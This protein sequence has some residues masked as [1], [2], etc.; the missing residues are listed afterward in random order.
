MNQ[1]DTK[2]CRD[3]PFSS[4]GKINIVKMPAL[5]KTTYRFNAIPM[6]LLVAFSTKLAQKQIV[7][8]IRQIHK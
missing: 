7:L 5:Q 8:L 1:N 2:K 6:Q 4:S 3:V